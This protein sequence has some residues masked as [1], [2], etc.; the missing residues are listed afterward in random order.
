ME[1]V[2]IIILKIVVVMTDI[3][4]VASVALTSQLS[5]TRVGTVDYRVKMYQDKGVWWGEF[6]LMMSTILMSVCELRAHR[7]S[8]IQYRVSKKG[9]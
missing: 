2:A 4:N 8:Q 3:S 7:S 9:P 5:T 6:G 1:H